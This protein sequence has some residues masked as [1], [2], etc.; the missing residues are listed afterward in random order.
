MH[1][2]ETRKKPTQRLN[3]FTV[4][5]DNEDRQFLI[6]DSHAAAKQR[7]AKHCDLFSLIVR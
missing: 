2:I 7:R 6:F 3:G 5:Q 4:Q 1:S